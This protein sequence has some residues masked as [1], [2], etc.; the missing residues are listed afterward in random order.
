M[1]SERNLA[2]GFESVWQSLFPM[3]TPGFM[4]TFNEHF[5]KDI[6][7]K[8]TGAAERVPVNSDSPDLVAELGIQIARRAI[9]ADVPVERIAGDPTALERAWKSAQTLVSRYEGDAP[10]LEEVPL[11]DEDGRD[12]TALARNLVAFAGLIDHRARF[13]PSVPGAG[14]LSRCE[15]DLALGD[16]LVE[17]KTVS[18]GFRSNDLRQLLVYHALDWTRGPRWTKGCL[19]NPRRA[20]WADFEVA[21]LVARLSG[22]PAADTF[23]DFVD[24]FASGIELETTRF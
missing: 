24:A 22:R 18:R 5:V 21:W 12:G 17:I 6:D 13:A 15:A 4:R 10:E 3:L 11:P 7:A 2:R 20:V 1:I 8:R 9:A 19:V 16:T 23:G 14:L